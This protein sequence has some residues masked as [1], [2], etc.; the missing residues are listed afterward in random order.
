MSIGSAVFLQ[1]TLDSAYT[2]Q[3][4]KT[5]PPKLPLPMRGSM[6]I[7]D[8]WFYGPIRVQNSNSNGIRSVH[9]FCSAHIVES[10]RHTQTRLSIVPSCLTYISYERQWV[11]FC[12]L[13][14]RLAV[15]QSR[16]LG[17][18]SQE[19]TLIFGD[20]TMKG[21]WKSES[22]DFHLPFIVLSPKMGW[23]VQGFRS[24]VSDSFHTIALWCGRNLHAK[25]RS[26]CY[27]ATGP[28][29]YTAL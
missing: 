7:A 20:N 25:T 22:S 15:T 23:W 6:P 9:Q 8:T 2:L 12:W 24:S 18:V 19:R 5:C 28:A 14:D 3:W 29:A 27:L 11:K 26:I 21:R 13:H 4:E 10:N 16:L 17:K 1:V